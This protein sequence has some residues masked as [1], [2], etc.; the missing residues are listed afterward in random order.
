MEERVAVNTKYMP[1]LLWAFIV[2]F[3]IFGTGIFIF[4]IFIKWYICF[5]SI[6]PF[7]L[8]YLIYKGYEETTSNPITYKAITSWGEI[9]GEYLKE[10]KD[11]F[12]N[13]FPFFYHFIPVN[14]T[15]KDRT[16]KFEK[17]RCKIEED[18]ST[19][20]E[21]TQSGGAVDTSITI[22]AEADEERF[23]HLIRNGGLDGVL[24]RF[25]SIVGED[26]RQ[27]CAEYTWEE[28]TF[29]KDLL[30]AKLI[31]K[32]VGENIE[33][34]IKGDQSFE[35]IKEIIEKG[36]AGDSTA[37]EKAKEVLQKALA[38]GIGDVVDLGVIIRRLNVDDI[39]PEEAIAEKASGLAVEIL[40]KR[41]EDMNL[42]T[43]ISQARKLKRAYN[44]LGEDVVKEIRQRKSIDSGQGKSFDIPGLSD[45]VKKILNK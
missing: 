39:K 11:L 38:N 26:Y 15:K 18:I 42:E 6:V 20:G 44:E 8:S 19:D 43:E 40:E 28:M 37:Q 1:K 34:H 22:T 10:G 45:V 2:I 16:Y 12:A 14:M 17:T 24:A 33:E 7:G 35:N 36:K 23:I 31:L 27:M 25:E 41:K 29:A 9:T 3:F 32:I 5:V 4:G 21:K 30:S 13:Y